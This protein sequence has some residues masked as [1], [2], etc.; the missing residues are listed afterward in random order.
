MDHFHKLHTNTTA[1]D[2][3]ICEGYLAFLQSGNTGDYWHTLWARGGITRER[4]ETMDHPITGEC[5]V[6]GSGV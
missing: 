1:E 6:H 2:V 4:L 3:T 5:A